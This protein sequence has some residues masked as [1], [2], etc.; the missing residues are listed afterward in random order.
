[1]TV[2]A[3]RQMRSRTLAWSPS[4]IQAG[5]AKVALKISCN[6]ARGVLCQPARQ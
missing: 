2:L 4:I 6:S 1:M 5:A 3:S